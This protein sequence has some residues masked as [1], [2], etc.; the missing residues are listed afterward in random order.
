MQATRYSLTSRISLAGFL[1]MFTSHLLAAVPVERVIWDFAPHGDGSFPS[2]GLVADSAGNLYGV[3]A[4]GGAGP[5]NNGVVFEMTPDTTA[6]GAWFETILYSF[7]DASGDGATPDGTLIFDKVGNLYGTTTSGGSGGDGTIFE[8]SPPATAGGA[9]TETVLYSFPSSG[10]VGNRPSGKLAFD[11]V[12]NLYGTTWYG[13]T[14]I[15]CGAH[16]GCGTVY[17]LAPP[18]TIGGAWTHTVL[19]NFGVS[20]TDG[21]WPAVSGVLY[22]GGALYGATQGGGVNGEGTV[23]VLIPT[24]SGYIEHHLHDFTAREGGGPSG[25]LIVDSA[26]NFYGTTL[27]GGGSTNCPTGCG[28]IY[29]LSPPATAG[30]AWTETTLY[31]FTGGLDGGRPWASLWRDQAGSLYGTATQGGLSS[32]SGVVFRLKPPATSGGPWTL[33]PLHE[34]KGATA[35]GSNPYGELIV[36]N[37]VFYGTTSQGGSLLLGSVFSVAP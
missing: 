19:H 31:S 11:P 6:P 25:G 26:N 32:N 18:A 14:G 13:G 1:L 34:F 16:P 23:F 30:G 5:T 7:G 20:A 15:N 2:N 17:R 12:G 24:S 37:H 9:W 21:V 8:L 33:V 35:D 22:R 29:V 10:K 28:A 3:T 27:W 4:R 36:V